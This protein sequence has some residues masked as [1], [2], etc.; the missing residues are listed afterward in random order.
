MSRQ[1]SKPLRPGAEMSSLQ[2]SRLSI[3][4][5]CLRRLQEEGVEQ[6]S[7]QVLADRFD[8]SAALIRKDLAHFGE[9]GIRGHGYDV[10]ALVDRLVELFGLS[11]EQPVIVVGMGKLGSALT[12]HFDYGRGVFRVVAGLDNDAQ[13]IG[14]RIG[15]V[16]V[17]PVDDIEDVVRQTSARIGL[18][19]VPREAAQD[20]FDIMVSAGVRSVLN[21]APTRLVTDA[22]KAH[23]LNV[24]L[25]IHLEELAYRI[26]S[27]IR[28]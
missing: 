18:L 11:R 3:Y 10:D 8:L 5:R 7:S 21:F 9:L 25:G 13:K 14:S 12:E 23:V 17:R 2:L 19:T 22:T 4:L 27:E 15:S 16:L 24:D 1:P 26:Q 28:R 6:V 20:T